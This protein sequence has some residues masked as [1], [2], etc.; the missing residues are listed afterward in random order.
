MDASADVLRAERELQAAQRASDVEALDRLLHPRLL[1]VGPEGALTDKA[2][3]LAAHRDGI[4][5]IRS[6]TEESV[7]VLV[8]D[9][10]AVTFVVLDIAGSIR[11][12][13]VSGLI[14]Y[15]RTWK[16]EDGDWRVLA[17]H[18]APL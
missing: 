14:R 17:A 9:D 7:E 12:D 13:D 3:D 8:A 15:T 10:V 4:F 5:E 1:A 2:A 6:L 11:G 16:R 18:I